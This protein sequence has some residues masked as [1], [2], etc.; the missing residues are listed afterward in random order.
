MH[1]TG[2]GVMGVYTVEHGNIGKIIVE[3]RADEGWER[4]AA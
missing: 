1:Q 4:R 2:V 3:R